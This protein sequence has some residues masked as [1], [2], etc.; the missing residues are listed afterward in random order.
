[1]PKQNRKR[2]HEFVSNDVEYEIDA[3]KNKFRPFDEE[4]QAE[5]EQLNKILFGGASSF[6]KS[7][8]EAE[9][10]T[11]ASCSN[12]DSGVGEDSEDS[13]MKERSPAWYDEDDDGIE[14]GQALDVQGR[15][16]P[17]GGINNRGN[18]YSSLLKHKFNSIMGT[19]AWA[20]LNKNKSQD[21]DSDDEI[22]QSCGFIRK[23]TKENLTSG[24]LEFKKVKDL[25][26]E[27]YGEG[28]YINA[29]EFHPTSQ[30]ALVA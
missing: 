29:V 10:E 3:P 13:E 7:L 18:K 12:I 20:S 4:A 17:A 6:L 15:K 21:S 28:P 19:P 9:Q 14:V 25:N 11:G 8:E 16:L 23:A 2:R 5:E 30:V 27:T 24:I 1:M 26:S 22:L